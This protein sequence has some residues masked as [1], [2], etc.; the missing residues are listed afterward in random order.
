MGSTRLPGK[1]MLQL[2]SRRVLEWVVH[3]GRQVDAIDDVVVAVGDGPENVMLQEWADRR[4]V[5]VVQG[6]EDDLLER[7]RRVAE[8]TDCDIMVRVTS[9]CP[10]VPPAEVERLLALY[11]ETDA[12]YVTNRTEAMPTGTDIDVI[13]PALLHRLSDGD[14][15]HPVKPMLEATE[16]WS[17]IV[18][19]D[20]SWER[21]TEAHTAV[22][23]PEDYWRLWDGLDA[24]GSNPRDITAWV[25]KQ[26]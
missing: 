1:V 11:R 18:T 24:I 8:T 25:A 15:S 4:G 5:A 22:D 3:R 16:E 14:A 12:G 20:E 2:G 26:T 10:F 9:D 6:P 21:F 19:G 23:T 17:A 7:H 13:E